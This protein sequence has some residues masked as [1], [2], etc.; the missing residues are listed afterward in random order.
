M[1]FNIWTSFLHGELNDEVYMKIPEGVSVN[2]NMRGDKE[3]V[4]NLN[5]ALC[6]LKQASREYNSK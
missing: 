6:G 3:L 4:S 5:K 2:D 1:Q